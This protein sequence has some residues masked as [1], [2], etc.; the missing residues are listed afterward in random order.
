MMWFPAL[1]QALVLDEADRLLEMGFSE[2]IRE[3]V[4]MAP[5]RRQT[6]LFSGETLAAGVCWGS[7]GRF[8]VE[9]EVVKTAPVRRQT[10]LFPVRVGC[11]VLSSRERGQGSCRPIAGLREKPGARCC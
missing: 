6:M 4:K 5:A 8:G 2:E 9:V 3:V 11:A 7:K 1:L 10:I